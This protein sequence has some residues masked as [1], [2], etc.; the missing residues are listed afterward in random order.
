MDGRQWSETTASISSLVLMMVF[1]G[2]RLFV[3]EVGQCLVQEGVLDGDGLLACKC[4]TCD[5][6][7]GTKETKRDTKL[8]EGC[9]DADVC[10]VCCTVPCAVTC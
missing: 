8:K 6:C 7:E 2:Q 4:A 5:K 3:S 10:G 1:W 9:S